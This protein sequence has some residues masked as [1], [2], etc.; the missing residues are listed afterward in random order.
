MAVDPKNLAVRL[1]LARFYAATGKKDQAEQALQQ[2]KKE[3]ADDPAAYRLVGDYYAAQGRLDD[4]IVEFGNLFQQ[5]P[6]DLR[7]E[8][9]YIEL[10]L[11]RGRLDDAE[12]LTGQLLK[13]GKNDAEGMIFHGILELARG[14]PA[15]AIPV[16]ESAL[17]YVPDNALAHYELGLAA[18]QVG[19]LE[20]AER[21][22]REAVRLRPALLEA[23]LALAGL[24]IGKGNDPL[25]D[26]AAESV[27]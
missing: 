2:T 19:D 4:A 22:W 3:L 21:E 24:A 25:L 18:D 9:T 16:L 12:K 8:K 23:Q 15:E 26:Q 20:R 17:K 11:R 1:V 6:K 5:H 27:I 7:I 14:R 10:L 13:S